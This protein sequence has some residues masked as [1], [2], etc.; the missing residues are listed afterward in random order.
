MTE[1]YGSSEPLPADVLAA[2]HRGN[3][4]EAIKRLSVARRIDLGDA[5]SIVDAYIHGDFGLKRK[6]QQQAENSRRVLMLIIAAAVVLAL[7]FWLF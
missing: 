1:P 4:I 3:K 2:L 7:S 6:Y 5:K